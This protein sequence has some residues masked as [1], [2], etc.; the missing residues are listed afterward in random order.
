MTK[1]AV[2]FGFFVVVCVLFVMSAKASRRELTVGLVDMYGDTSAIRA[3]TIEGK[4]SGWR[5]LF[6]YTFHISGDEAST[7]MVVFTDNRGY[8]DFIGHPHW[9]IPWH[10]YF[11][12]T[13]YVPVGDYTLETVERGRRMHFDI[14]DSYITEYRVYGEVF[15]VETRLHGHRV[16]SIES[17]GHGWGANAGN[18]EDGVAH[19]LFIDAGA[20]GYI[21]SV[22]ADAPFAQFQNNFWE[23]GHWGTGNRHL[24]PL[25]NS[26]FTNSMQVFVHTGARLFGETAVYGIRL[27][28]DY[29]LQW[30]G[31]LTHEDTRFVLADELLPI[32]LALGDEILGLIAVDGGFLLLVSRTDALEVTHYDFATGESATTRRGGQ[33]DLSNIYAD[34]NAVVFRGFD[35]LTGLDNVVWTVDLSGEGMLVSQPALFKLGGDYVTDNHFIQ[36]FT[37]LMRDGVVFFAYTMEWNPWYWPG[38]VRTYISAFAPDGQL[39][40][41]VRVHNGVEEDGFWTFDGGA[42]RPFARQV[43]SITLG[44]GE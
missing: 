16:V 7:E 8:A 1:I 28:A 11:F 42:Q 39:L 3:L 40:G 36:V 25:T 6:G 9:D 20:G 34:G 44:G 12:E 24:T 41:R 18:L 10:P 2:S 13:V 21:S 38:S 22:I 43:R 4:V 26:F 15:A 19:R 5:G 37:S 27:E 33:I 17:A 29:G 32:S 30:I 23:V 31:A 14:E 35:R